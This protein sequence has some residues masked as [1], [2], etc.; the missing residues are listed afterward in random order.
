[1][2]HLIDIGSRVPG[3]GDPRHA[4][5]A[6]HRYARPPLGKRLGYLFIGCPKPGPRRKQ[7]WIVKISCDQCVAKGLRFHACRHRHPSGHADHSQCAGK[8]NAESNVIERLKNQHSSPLYGPKNTLSTRPYIPL[9]NPN[10]GILVNCFRKRLEIRAFA[11]YCRQ[12]YN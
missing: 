4:V 8:P 11:A 5:V 2:T 9:Q 10:N 3:I 12:Q 6:R 1:M 7:C